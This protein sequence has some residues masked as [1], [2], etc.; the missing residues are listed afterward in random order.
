MAHSMA[1]RVKAGIALLNRKRPGWMR[2]INLRKLDLSQ[3]D[4]QEDGCGC[5]LAQVYGKY[6]EGCN[7]LFPHSDGSV[8]HGFEFDY[9][10]DVIESG[11]K[12]SEVYARLTEEWRRQIMQEGGP[13]VQP[14]E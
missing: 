11:Q 9:D 10:D 2:S 4:L 14:S 3:P 5:V 1:A 6:Q 12:P 7:I 13:G 8:Q